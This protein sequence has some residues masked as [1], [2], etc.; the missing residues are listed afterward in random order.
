MP[1]RIVLYL[2]VRSR[3]VQ[4]RYGNLAIPCRPMQPS[5]GRL[6]AFRA[7]RR[8]AFHPPLLQIIPDSTL[9]KWRVHSK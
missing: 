7:N 5:G 6:P 4:R 2:A 1:K 9:I 8:A 3:R